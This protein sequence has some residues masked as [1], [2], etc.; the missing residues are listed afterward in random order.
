MRR[1]PIPSRFTPG[2]GMNSRRLAIPERNRARL[3]QQERI[4]IAGG[5]HRASRHGE[6]VVLHQAVHTGDADG[7]KQSAN[8]GWNQANQQR[9]QDEHGLW[10]ARSR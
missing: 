10:R 1:R 7:R 3:I 8:G 5:L 4:D 6:H 9:H 2:A